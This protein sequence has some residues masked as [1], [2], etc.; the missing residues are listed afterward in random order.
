MLQEELY[1]A[2]GPAS[3]FGKLFNFFKTSPG[4]V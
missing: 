3:G 2:E 1:G 4:E